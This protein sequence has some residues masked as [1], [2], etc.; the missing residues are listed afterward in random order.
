MLTGRARAATNAAA[1]VSDAD[2]LQFA[3]NLEYLEAEY[4]LYATTGQGLPPGDI[5]G[6][7]TLGTTTIK[8]N[9]KVP[10]Q[11]PLYQQYAQEIATDEKDHVEYL[12]AALS[13][14]G[15]TPVARPPLDL[16]NSFNTLA[17]AAGIGQSFDPFE[18]EV[19]FLLG[20]FI[21][22]DVGVSAYRGGAGLLTNS[23]LIFAAAGVLGTEAYHAGSIRTTLIALQDPN[24][25]DI[26][27]KISDLRDALDGPTPKD[28]GLLKRGKA[29]AIL[30]DRNG[31]VYSRNTRQVL[32]IVYGAPNAS[33]GLFYPNGM[34]GAI[35]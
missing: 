7:G 35:S 31:L 12:R 8:A 3:L 17:Q 25:Y 21:F 20:A 34:N 26:A 15:V 4:Y 9:P 33:S 28:G 11:D 6:S 29:N 2:I 14:L 13:S 24:V 16:L 19:N 23:D 18:N 30:T 32:N 27:Q 22:E 5:T 1:A 10:F